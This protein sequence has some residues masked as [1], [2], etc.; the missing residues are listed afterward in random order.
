ML[1]RFQSFGTYLT[2]PRATPFLMPLSVSASVATS[3]VKVV[4]L[5]RISSLLWF[6]NMQLNMKEVQVRLGLV[7]TIWSIK[8]VVCLRG[9]KVFKGELPTYFQVSFPCDAVRTLL[10]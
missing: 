7:T 4:S 2:L 10:A 8:Q 6:V 1:E 3:E 5:I 9:G